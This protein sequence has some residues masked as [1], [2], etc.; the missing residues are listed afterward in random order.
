[1][2]MAVSFKFSNPDSFGVNL[3]NFW[4]RNLYFISRLLG[5]FCKKWHIMSFFDLQAAIRTAFT[6]LPYFRSFFRA[7]SV[8]NICRKIMKLSIF[9]QWALSEISRN[10]PH[11]HIKTTPFQLAKSVTST[12]IRHFNKTTSLQQKF[13]TC[14]ICDVWKWRVKVTDLC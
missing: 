3:E 10:T 6:T 4:Y 2:I 12:R 1:M 9:G 7:R 13:V 5:D 14:G 8:L 11:F